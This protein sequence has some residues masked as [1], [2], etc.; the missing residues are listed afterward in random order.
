MPSADLP[1]PHPM[2]LRR[3]FALIAL[4]ASAVIWHAGQHQLAETFL[5]PLA[6]MLA[7]VMVF[8]AAAVL[9]FNLPILGR[10]QPG[11]PEPGPPRHPA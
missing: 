1:S 2:S 10:P 11:S 6:L 3:I 9:V 4:A 5:G 8:L 7:P